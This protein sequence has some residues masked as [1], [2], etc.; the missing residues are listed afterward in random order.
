MG[1]VQQ[2][3]REGKPLPPNCAVDASGA[4]TI[5]P[6]QAVALLPFGEH[7]GY[8]T[9]VINELIA[10]FIGGS[11]PT[12]RGRF[13]NDE[14]KHSPCFFFFVIHPDA[15]SSCDFA[16]AR[17]RIENLRLVAGDILGN[18]N[19]E[20]ILPGQLEANQAAQSDQHG[21]FFFSGAEV[22]ALN[23]IAVECGVAPLGAEC[24]APISQ[25]VNVAF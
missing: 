24:I 10:A 19:E 2:F 6:V 25:D 20:A 11:L 17:T 7:K 3:Q 5:D 21:G 18:G 9:G 4:V 15:I 12:L 14:E 13:W 8:E 1:R 22:D 16:A 23:A